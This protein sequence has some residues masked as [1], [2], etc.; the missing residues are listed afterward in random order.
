MI[1]TYT[2]TVTKWDWGCERAQSVPHDAAST[3][4]NF[5]SV[6]D[7]QFGASLV[8]RV[9]Q[10]LGKAAVGLS[11]A[12]LCQ[13]LRESGDCRLHGEGVFLPLKLEELIF[14]RLRPYLSLS[15]VVRGPVVMRWRHPDSFKATAAA[16]YGRLN[17]LRANAFAVASYFAKLRLV[18]GGHY[19]VRVMH[20]TDQ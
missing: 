4:D 10:L 13:L 2:V 17:R 12:E 20:N 14:G 15:E 3:V 11:F 8:G 9:A 19:N 5:F 7:A 18:V 6:L 1:A 16:R